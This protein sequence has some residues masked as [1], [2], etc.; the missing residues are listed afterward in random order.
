MKIAAREARRRF[1]ASH[2][3]SSLAEQ[4]S[5]LATTVL[6]VTVEHCLPKPTGDMD[7]QKDGWRPDS[8]CGRDTTRTK[9]KVSSRVKKQSPGTPAILGFNESLVRLQ[10][11][12]FHRLKERCKRIGRW[13]DL[14]RPAF[15]SLGFNPNVSVLRLRSGI[16]FASIFNRRYQDP[17]GDGEDG[18][19][20]QEVQKSEGGSFL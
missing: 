3:S 17:H 1:L 14:G 13:L 8:W 12:K 16:C 20:C 6:L 4:A 18:K 10:T 2:V 5:S 9:E 15:L 7:P 11:R 19:Y